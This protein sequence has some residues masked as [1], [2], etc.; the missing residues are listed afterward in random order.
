MQDSLS[1]FCKSSFMVK[2][3]LH[4]CL[5]CKIFLSPS[6]LKYNLGL[7]VGKCI[8][9]CSP[10]QKTVNLMGLPGMFLFQIL[11]FFVLYFS[12]TNMP[13]WVFFSGHVYLGLYRSHVFRSLCLSHHQRNLLLLFHWIGFLGS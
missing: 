11:K 13:Q 1:T 2:N 8:L 7:L 10:G 9:P 12:L 5:S 4:F 3:S 6:I